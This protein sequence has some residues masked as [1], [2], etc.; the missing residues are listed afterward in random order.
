MGV[1]L[2]VVCHFSLF[3]FNILSLSLISLDFIT[4]SWCVL[5]C[6]FFPTWIS[7]LPGLGWLFPFPCLEIFQL[8]SLPIFYQTTSLLYSSRTPIMWMLVDLMLSQ[9]LLGNLHFIF[10]VFCSAALIST[11]LSF[12]SFIHSSA[13]LILLLIPY[14]VLFISVCLFF[15]SCRSLVNISYILSSVFLR[16]WL[17]I[18]IIILNYFSG[19][20]STFNSF[21]CFSGVL[22]CLFIWDIT[23]CFSIMIYFL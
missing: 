8:L 6:F 22:S 10:P 15:S 20:M 18:T 12:T 1:P 4:I 14:S 3:A 17:I 21:R 11:V 19:M 16:S 23:L 2:Y 9:G 13:L 5:H 7:L